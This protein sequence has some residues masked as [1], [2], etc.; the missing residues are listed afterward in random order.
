MNHL[1]A[2]VVIFMVALVVAVA[3]MI[4]GAMWGEG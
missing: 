3:V 1:L 4:A 2:A